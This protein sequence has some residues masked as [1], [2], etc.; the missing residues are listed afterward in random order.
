MSVDTE[1]D[2]EALKIIGEI[3]ANCLAW[4]KHSAKPGMTTEELDEIGSKFLQKYGANSAPRKVYN[5]PGATCISVENE[6]VHGVPGSQMLQEGFLVNVDV[7]AEKDGYFADTGGSFVLGHGSQEKNFLCRSTK[8]ALKVALKEV[9]QGAPINQ[10]GKAIQNHVE[11][12]GLRVVR[13]VGG[14]GVGRSLHEEPGFIANFYDENDSRLFQQN[15]VLAI[16]PIISTGADYLKDKGDGWT[17]HHPKF[18]TAQFEHT[19][20]VTKNKPYIFTRPSMHFS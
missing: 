14:H 20:L 15:S 4:M 7:S 11:K 2:F 5:F 13:N 12:L 17:L 8:Q 9:R 19:V 10:M 6:G 18:Y 1:K 3:V 16:E